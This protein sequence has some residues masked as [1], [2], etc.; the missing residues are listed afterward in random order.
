RRGRLLALLPAPAG[1]RA[2]IG[3]YVHAAGI[4]TG[5]GSNPVGLDRGQP[6]ETRLVELR[7]LG[8]RVVIEALNTRYRALSDDPAE[9]EAARESF[10][11]S[12]LFATEILAEDDEGTL[13]VDLSDFL[14][15][16]A[17]GIAR[18]LAAAGQGTWSLDARRSAID[19]D[20]CRAF[21]ENVELESWLTFVGSGPAPEVE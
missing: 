9:V 21:P 2:S 8:G 6:G 1:P 20:S 3:L 4:R 17:H 18:R 16:D 15:R 7:R 10:A 14:L 11:T 5:L 13:L 19:L 12:I